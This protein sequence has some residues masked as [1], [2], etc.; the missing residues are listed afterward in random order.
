MIGVLLAAEGRPQS[1]A[2]LRI[3]PA[4]AAGSDF[5]R[6]FDEITFVPLESSKRS[7]FGQIDGLLV[8][9]DYFI[10]LDNSSTHSILIF[11]KNGDFHAR[12]AKQD[13]VIL[14]YFSYDKENNRL[15]VC[16]LRQSAIPPEAMSAAMNN[17]FEAM[18]IFIKYAYTRY[19]DMNGQPLKDSSAQVI[20]FTDFASVKLSKGITAS[21]FALADKRLPD[22][23]GYQLVQTKDGKMSGSWFPYNTQKDLARCGK[24]AGSGYFSQADNDTTFYFTRPLDYTVYK[25]NAG[26]VSPVYKF[27]FPVKN[28]VPE[29]YFT[30]TFKVESDREAWFGSHPDCIKE[31]SAIYPFGNTL[32]FKLS[33]FRDVFIYGI[34]TGDLYALN[35][36]TPDTSISWLPLLGDIYNMKGISAKG[37][38]Y[39]YIGVSSFEMFR[40]KEM[41]DEKHPSY[42][43]ILE[44]Y[45][46]TQN[47][48]SNPV[49]IRLK[50]KENI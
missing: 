39:I 18:S 15:L 11:D 35:R 38:P 17:P 12:V 13:G 33:A 28:T 26:M 27:I 2:R 47:R 48:K 41:A 14:P 23:T 30:D 21:S 42:P 45:F 50:P 20:K 16:F 25:I 29:K 49:I 40:A 9:E 5:S 8:T 19:F 24:A 36:L 31:I 7:L 43:T 46:K 1:P 4:D 3:D 44:T 32:F 6:I 22:S 34:K 10:I 37:G